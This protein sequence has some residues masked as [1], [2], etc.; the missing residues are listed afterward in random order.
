MLA[1]PAIEES[2]GL[3]D[4]PVLYW[5]HVGL[6]MNRITHSLGG[7]QGGPTMS[8]R[9]LGLLH[10]AMH[11]AY[12]ATLGH[13]ETSDPPTYLPD[14]V[15]PAKPAELTGT[16]DNANAA[17]TAAAITVLDL[18]YGGSGSGISITARDTLSGA[19]ATMIAGY[20]PHINALSFAHEF[21]AEIANA[22]LGR[23]AVKPGEPGA[24]QGHYE[25]KQ[26][27]FMFR[28]EPGNPLRRVPIDPNN[29]AL[30]TRAQRTYHGPFYG[31]TVPAFAVTDPDGHN[32][33][34]W[35]E[36][37][38]PDALR[39]V[40]RLGGAVGQSKTGRTPDE[41]VAGLYWAYD[42]ANLIGTPPRLYNQILRKIA[43]E[44]RDAS[45]DAQTQTSEFVRLFAL[46]NAAM[47]DAGKFAWLEKFKFELWRPLS[48]VREHAVSAMPTNGEGQTALDAD[49]DPFW[50]AL[51]APET[52]TN[53]ISFKP[54]FP[55]Y[56][57]GHATFGAA[58]F[59]MA[60]L[61]YNRTRRV[62]R[63]R[64]AGRHRLQ[65]RLRGT[66]RSKPRP[67][68]GPRS[69]DPDRGPARQRSDPDK[70]QVSAR[71]GTRSSRT[72]SAASTWACTGA[73]TPPTPP[74]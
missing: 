23:L 43:W 15:R 12:F 13:T 42:G 46:A 5:N 1:L 58:C 4:F 14:S 57:S 53:R 21:G 61:Y 35:P 16:L 9:A 26:G 55:A 73:L 60:R 24:D 50:I 36:A 41:T 6:Q 3:N 31:K 51:G 72:P 19:L 38:Y 27:R 33:A 28:D 63:Q 66:Q 30:G 32:L 70:P 48:G 10:L 20:G 69:R 68:P 65:L 11:D 39:E 44:R 40:V 37:D 8:S 2:P 22:I 74:T 47:A 34:V 29:P 54:P 45:A 25:T 62:L 71:S 18:L 52:N 59:Q 17:L 56:P 67:A 64:R 7:P 49:A